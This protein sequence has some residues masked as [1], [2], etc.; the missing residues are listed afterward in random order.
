LLTKSNHVIFFVM[1]YVKLLISK[2]YSAPPRF[3]GGLVLNILGYHILRIIT[4]NL[5]HSL[6][7]KK[8]PKDPEGRRIYREVL[9]NGIVSIPYFFPE[10]VFQKIKEECYRSEKE[11]I[12][13][14]SPRMLRSTLVRDDKGTSNPILEKYLA[15]ND[16]INKVVSALLG[17]DILISPKVYFEETFYSDEDLGKPTSDF[18]DHLHFDVSYPTVKCLYYLNDVNEDNAAFEF[19]KGSQKMTLKRLWL[20]YKMSV[21][22]WLWS[23]ERRERE[24][25]E[26]N[27]DFMRRNKMVATPIIGQGNTLV[28]ANTMG[29]HRRGIHRTTKPRHLIFVDYRE[30]ETL[31]FLKRKLLRHA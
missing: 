18:Q 20:E 24:F 6:R 30:L 9:D 10:D 8:L 22:F 21:A 19:V 12:S 23:K 14:K 16:L 28:I 1:S 4:F 11:V 2:L 25:P 31:K 26:I 5:F 3:A 13:E 7:K 17:K 29:F 15:K 27:L